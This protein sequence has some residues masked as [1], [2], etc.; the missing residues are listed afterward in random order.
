MKKYL[1]FSLLALLF[2]TNGFAQVLHSRSV[3]VKTRAP[4]QSKYSSVPYAVVGINFAKYQFDSE[5]NDSEDNIDK[6]NPK[7]TLGYNFGI[8][9][10]KQ[11]ADYVYFGM[12]GGVISHGFKIK[13]SDVKFIGHSVYLSPI[14]FG[15][16]YDIDEQMSVEAGIGFFLRF[17]FAQNNKNNAFF[18]RDLDKFNLGLNMDITFNYDRYFFSLYTQR[19][20]KNIFPDKFADGKSHNLLFRAG[21]KF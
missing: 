2:C 20:F 19:G 4:R 13:N 8:G 3:G 17:D 21:I 10:K 14:N 1:L 18:L 6:I 11:L 5:D 9:F 16:R 12:E 15:G 7:R